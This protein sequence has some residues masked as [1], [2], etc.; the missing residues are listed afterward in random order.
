MRATELISDFSVQRDFFIET[1]DDGFDVVRS[2]VEMNKTINFA[3]YGPSFKMTQDRYIGNY[4][5]MVKDTYPTPPENEEWKEET[6]LLMV[7]SIYLH[8]VHQIDPK[9]GVQNNPSELLENL[10]IGDHEAPAI[11]IVGSGLTETFSSLD[12]LTLRQLGVSIIPRLIQ[13]FLYAPVAV[14][15][16]TA[17]TVLPYLGFVSIEPEL[18]HYVPVLIKLIDDMK[19]IF[20]NIEPLKRYRNKNG[21]YDLIFVGLNHTHNPLQNTTFF[22]SAH[23]SLNFIHVGETILSE[24]SRTRLSETNIEDVVSVVE[25]RTELHRYI[26]TLQIGYGVLEPMLKE[27]PI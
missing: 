14:G 9:S 7:K 3:E 17:D 20:N 23:F 4:L 13:S 8:R 18:P 2:S 15:E 12:E 26:T 1:T 25:R 16:L 10:V 21:G 27:S 5:N 24:P 19:I 11:T 6:L 22:G